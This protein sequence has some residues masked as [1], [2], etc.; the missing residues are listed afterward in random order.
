MN[1]LKLRLDELEVTSFEVI[2]M[3][4]RG[5]GTVKGREVTDP[6]TTY[7]YTACADPGCDTGATNTYCVTC[8]VS[9]CDTVCQSCDGSCGGISCDPSYCNTQCPTCTC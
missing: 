5:N 6:A 1:K 7:V 9:N 4:R 8:D 3:G 2:S